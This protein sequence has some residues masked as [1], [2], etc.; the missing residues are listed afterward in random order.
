MVS[1]EKANQDVN[2]QQ[3]EHT[4]SPG[5]M[6]KARRETLGLSQQAVADKLFLK[7]RQIDDLENDLL[8]EKSSITFTKGYVRNYAKQLGLNAQEVIDAFEQYHNQTS[9]PSSA[10]L[11]SFSKRVAKQTQDDRWMMVTYVILLLIIAAV[12]VWWYQQPNDETAPDV[13]LTEAIKREAANT[14]ISTANDEEDLGGALNSTEEVP[15][16]PT[17]Q[18]AVTQSLQE[19]S[20][21]EAVSNTLDDENTGFTQEGDLNDG[22][23]SAPV[24]SI[25][26]SNNLTAVVEEITSQDET[27]EIVEA[28]ANVPIAMVFTFVDDCW[29]N[30]KDA[31]GEAIAYGVKQKGRVMEIQG[32]SPVEV[33]L[34]AANNVR[35]TVN[36]ESVDLSAYHNGRT[37]RFTLP[38]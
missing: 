29:V 36:G 8:D 2:S 14:P 34:G 25:D 3:Q 24:S 6:L 35:L 7:A 11:Q 17:R 27:S 9:V 10:K 4:P 12:V 37:A 21:D 30:I 26:D 20:E 5:A 38:M 18:E 28:D 13:P 16:P 22:A 31:T 1:E 23:I 33:T 19:T 32:L 15:L